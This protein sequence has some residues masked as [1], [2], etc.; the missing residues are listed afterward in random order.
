MQGIYK[1]KPRHKDGV[2]NDCAEINPADLLASYFIL[3][4]AFLCILVITSEHHQLSI[5][6]YLHDSG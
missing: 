1:C 6:V 3:R 5:P 4:K 2:N